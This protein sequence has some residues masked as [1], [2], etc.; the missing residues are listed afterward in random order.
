VAK[1]PKFV[2]VAIAL[3]ILAWLV[4]ALGLVYA[5]FFVTDPP[6]NVVITFSSKGL[7]RLFAEV[8]SL[9]IG[10]LGLVLSVVAFVRTAGD[11]RLAL[12][13]LSSAAVC[14]VCVALLM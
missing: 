3:A 12:A 4:L 5:A 13:A 2:A 9:G 10:C 8:L 11:R 6:P 1:T 14:A 7:T